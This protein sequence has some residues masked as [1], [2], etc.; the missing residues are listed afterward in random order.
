MDA[1]RFEQA[2]SKFGGHSSWAYWSMPG[3]EESKGA[4]VGD[5]SVFA[6]VESSEVLS[7]L[8]TNYVLM[9]LNVS[10][11]PTELAQAFCNFHD[12]SSAGRDYRLRYAIH[13]TALWGAYMT[14]FFV[15]LVDPKAHRVMAYARTKPEEVERQVAERKKELVCVGADNSV[16][17]AL[18]N[19]VHNLLRKHCS[20]RKIIKIPH[21]SAYIKLEKYRDIVKEVLQ[22][23]GA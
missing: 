13:D 23:E 6:S 19:D 14:D 21:Y 3:E 4:R 7:S 10:R 1:S 9:G 20:D 8:H 11:G 12:G 16:I 5:L 18:G 22:N 15:D 2:R 17:V